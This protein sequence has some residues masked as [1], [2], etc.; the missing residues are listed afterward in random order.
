MVNVT[1]VKLV[2][3]LIVKRSLSI[4]KRSIKIISIEFTEKGMQRWLKKKRTRI[5][6]RI[7]K[8]ITLKPLCAEISLI[9]ASA[10]IRIVIMLIVKKN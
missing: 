6:R 4:T 3:M 2:V 5:K 1:T 7:Q 8:S 9:A 10:L